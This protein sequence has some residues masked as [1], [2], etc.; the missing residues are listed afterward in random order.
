[1]AYS[2]A[3]TF[4]HNAVSGILA[5]PVQ[6]QD[7]RNAVLKADG[8]IAARPEQ[9]QIGHGS[10]QP[11]LQTAGWPQLAQYVFDLALDVLHRLADGAAARAGFG[12][13]GFGQCA[14]IDLEREQIRTDFVMQVAGDAGALF[15][16]HLYDLLLQPLVSA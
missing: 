6:R 3:E 9:H 2:V 14:G 1:M 16:L 5:A 13:D 7:E 12:V 10:F 15:F 8:G 11:E 4:L